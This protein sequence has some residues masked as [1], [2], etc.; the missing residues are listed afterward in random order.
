MMRKLLFLLPALVLTTF[1]ADAQTPSP[2]H[3]FKAGYVA[4]VGSGEV[5]P[6]QMDNFKKYAKRVLAAVAEE[7][8]T[9]A[10]EFSVQPDGKTVDLR[11]ISKCRSLRGACQT[12]EGHI[13]TRRKPQKAG[14]NNSFWLPQCGVE[15]DVSSSRTYVRNL[16]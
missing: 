16:H 10:F 1:S 9:L 14:E 13:Q 15:G 7:P 2:Q 12:Y 5:A 11:N 8:G 3:G 6:D 4:A